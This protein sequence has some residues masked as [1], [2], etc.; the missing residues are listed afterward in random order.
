[1]PLSISDIRLVS[2]FAM[3]VS[4]PL[5]NTTERLLVQIVS[6]TGDAHRSQHT[7]TLRPFTFRLHVRVR[8]APR[9]H[10]PFG[11]D[12]ARTTPQGYG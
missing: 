9:P 11:C 2:I 4:L 3:S 10:R 8:S 1:M 12:L 6:N 7:K 5:E